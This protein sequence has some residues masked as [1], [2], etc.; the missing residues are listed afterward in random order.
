[1]WFRRRAVSPDVDVGAVRSRLV[2]AAAWCTDALDN[3]RG[4]CGTDLMLPRGEAEIREERANGLTTPGFA[5]TTASERLEHAPRALVASVT[6]ARALRLAELGISAPSW[7][8]E[9][10]EAGRVL[11]CFVGASLDDR[12]CHIESRGF[13]D[14]DDLPPADTWFGLV[15][16]KLPQMLAWVPEP[17]VAD[18]DAAMP[19]CPTEAYK[20][21]ADVNPALER[22][23]LHGR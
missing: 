11:C 22:A 9:I 21:L 2:E 19:C 5:P 16:L 18:V 6:A 12:A 3:G 10:I 20:W 17:H 1:M 13:F 14:P 15:P 23:L 4:F 8:K 7:S